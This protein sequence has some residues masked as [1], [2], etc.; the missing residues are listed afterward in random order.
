LISRGIINQICLADQK[1]IRERNLHP[2]F[3][4][5]RVRFG[6]IDGIDNCC[7]A[8]KREVT[9]ETW[10]GNQRSKHGKR[11]SQPACFHNDTTHR[12]IL[13]SGAPKQSNKRIVQAPL[14]AAANAS[15][16]QQ[17]DIFAPPL[18]QV[19][20]KTDITSLVDDDCCVLKSGA[21]QQ[22]RK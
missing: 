10:I 18:D 7:N 20:I 16:L 8:G 3:G 17:H 1:T 11:I 13:I 19:V 2:C 21:A 9:A 6:K 4:K 14:Q 15:T 22:P 5:K 12:H